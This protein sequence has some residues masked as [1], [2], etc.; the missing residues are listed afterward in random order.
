MYRIPLS[1]PV[2]RIKLGKIYLPQ[3]QPVS[4]LKIYVY[5]Q[6]HNNK[7]M[8]KIINGPS[9]EVY[10]IVKDNSLINKSSIYNSSIYNSSIYNSSIY[11]SSIYNSS[12]YNSSIYNSSINNSSIYNSSIYNFV[13]LYFINFHQ[14]SFISFS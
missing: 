1:T 6:Q 14:I 9:T 5:R 4:T 10:N 8:I 2:Q 12:I 7:S 13:T 11:N 3:I